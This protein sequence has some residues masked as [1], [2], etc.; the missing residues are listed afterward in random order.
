[1]SSYKKVSL[2]SVLMQLTIGSMT[3]ITAPQCPKVEFGSSAGS[4]GDI[5]PGNS[6]VSKSMNE[7]LMLSTVTRV[8]LS[9]K[10]VSLGDIF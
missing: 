1:M 9:T 2:Q 3:K 5:C 6:F 7:L 10:S 4:N 8:V